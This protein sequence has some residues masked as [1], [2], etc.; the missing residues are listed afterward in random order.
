MPIGA[1][2]RQRTIKGAK[3]SAG[4]VGWGEM[5]MVAV[6]AVVII[7]RAGVMTPTED[8][9]AGYGAIR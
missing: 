9:N 6:A 4:G 3:I 7:T 5:M 2:S 1:A 8:D